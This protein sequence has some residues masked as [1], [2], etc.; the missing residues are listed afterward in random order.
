MSGSAQPLLEIRALRT[1]FDT[2]DGTVKVLDGLDLDVQR[3]HIVG[4]VGESG[5]GKSVTAYSI[6]RLVR[7]PGRIAGGEIRFAGRDLLAL[8]ESEMR[9]VRGKEISMIFQDPRGFLDPVT[10]VGALLTEIYRTHEGVSRKQAKA[11]ALEMVSAVGLP[12]PRRVMRSY[13]HELSGGMAQRAMIALALACAPKLL[14]ADE[15]TTAL[16]VTIQ[17]QIIRLLA[18][19]RERFGLTIILITHN[20]NVVAEICDDVAVM[21]AGQI[22]ELGPSV[23]IFER[24]RH[25][26]TVSLL[27]ARPTIVRGE[28]L[29]DIPGRV[30]DLLEPPSGCRFSPRCFMAEKICC[31]EAPALRP[32]RPGHRSRCH[33]AERLEDAAA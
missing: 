8:R 30:P 23:E 3:G 26:Y 1:Y 4:L 21:Y 24:P 20:L 25:P 7:P 5:S 32:L 19:L 2:P 15:P 33:F 6:M 14:I 9:K 17:I 22:V 13:P 29:A 18:N 27:R 10:R 11:R 16:D 31:E 12:A 28:R